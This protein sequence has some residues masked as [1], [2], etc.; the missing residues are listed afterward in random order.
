MKIKIILLILTCFL[1]F[2]VQ[3]NNRGWYAYWGAGYASN[4]YPS[5]VQNNFDI[6]EN[7]SR[8]TGAVD[9]FGF[10]W[11]LIN[12]GFVGFVVSGTADL[13]EDVLPNTNR[14]TK[15]AVTQ[16]LLG[17]SGMRFFGEKIG[18]GL[19]VRS[20]IGLAS[21]QESRVNFGKEKEDKSGYGILVGAGYAISFSNE[22]SVLPGF[23]VSRNNI[24]GK[25]YD[26]IRFV[27]GF[28]F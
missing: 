22:I 11:P 4:S 18:K 16:F 13:A 20:D 19:F 15:Y 28:L 14:K 24:G 5:E 9:M 27:V 1:S 7:G 17:L 26:S 23:T 25:S 2:N 6:L 12:N 10:Y 8:V 21:A 3:A